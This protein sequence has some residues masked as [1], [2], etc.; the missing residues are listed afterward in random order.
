MTAHE[1]SQMIGRQA[2]WSIFELQVPVEVT[3]ARFMFGRVDVQIKPVGGAGT[4]WCSVRAI[5]IEEDH[6]GGF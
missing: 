2:T 4:H 1:L 3:D 6:L 5:T